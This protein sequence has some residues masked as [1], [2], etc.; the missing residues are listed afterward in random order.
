MRVAAKTA[1]T[2][3]RILLVYECN[4]NVV[5]FDG[6]QLFTASGQRV[7]KTVG[8]TTYNYHYLGDQLVEMAWG[9]NRMH[10]TY[11]AVGPMS[12]NFN[13]TEYFYLKNAQGDVT[14]LVDSAGAKVVHYTYDPWGEVWS[15]GGTLSSTLGTLNPLRYRGYVYDTETGL[16]YV[17]SRYYDPEIG[18]WINA[19]GYV[20]TGQGVLGNNMFAYCGNNPVNRVDP[21]GQFWSEIWEFAKTAVA[22]IGKAMGVMSPAYAGCGGAAVADGPLPFGDIVAAAGAALLTVGAIGYGIYQ[23]T[24]A[25][26]ISIPKAE[27]KAEAIPAPPPTPTVIY[28]YGGTNPGNLTPKAK[29]KYTGLSF[30]TVPMPGAA[31][32]TIEALNA[33]GVVY[34][35]QDG[36]THVGVRPVGAPIEAW[37]NAGSGSIWIQAVK[38]VVI[39]WDGGY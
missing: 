29:D 28:R 20:S 11:D 9:A 31:M 2:S 19:D 1:Y 38:S 7:S 27:E 30:S 37:I 21:T 35:V 13:G 15:V 33:T 23:A 25:P 10:F 16:Y 22:E 26:A 18:R 6:V 4:A 34:A 17:S 3:L 12:V 14:G 5:Y 36:P 32:T 24:Q 39:K 8:G